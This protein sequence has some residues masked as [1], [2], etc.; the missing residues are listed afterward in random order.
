MADMERSASLAEA[1]ERRRKELGLTPNALAEATGLSL[2]A[3]RNIRRGEIRQYQERL[4]FP[5]TQALGWS[6]DSIDRILAGGDPVVV[7]VDDDAL[8]QLHAV[9]EAQGRVLV[10]LA[11]EAIAWLDDAEQLADGLDVLERLQD[12]KRAL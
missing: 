4:T 12:P 11:R 5:L 1:V 10:L 3:L 2:Q 8:S 6:P 9:V 7:E